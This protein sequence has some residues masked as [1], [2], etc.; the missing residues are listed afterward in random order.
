MTEK[1]ALQV[2]LEQVRDNG[3]KIRVRSYSGRGMF[4]AECMAVTFDRDVSET[5]IVT[6]ALERGYAVGT[7]AAVK[8]ALKGARFDNMGLGTVMY[9]PDVPYTLD[10]SNDDR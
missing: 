7:D 3:L 6:E 1:H 9:W 5:E 8:Q 2:A 4:G 10:D